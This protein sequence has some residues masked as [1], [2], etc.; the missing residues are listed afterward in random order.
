MQLSSAKIKNSFL[1]LLVIILF[2]GTFSRAYALTVTPIKYELSGDPGQVLQEKLTLRNEQD[3]PKTYYPSYYNFQAEG[4]TGA[5]T[6]TS[7]KEDL[8]TWMAAPAGVELAAGE[9]KE[10]TFTISI[11]KTAP[12]GGYFA[13]VL[14]GTIPPDQKGG[15]LAIGAQTGPIVLLRVNGD[16]KESASVIE[17]KTKGDRHFYTSLPVEMYYRFQNTGADRTKPGGELVI[18]NIFGI[19]SKSQTPNPVEGNV[20]PGQI[21]KFELM[22]KKHDSPAQDIYSKKTFFDAVSYEWRNFALGY[23]TANLN[24]VYGSNNSNIS[25]S[26]VKFAVFP[27]QLLVVLIVGAFLV[28]TILRTLVRRYNKWLIGQAEMALMR[29]E[30]KKEKREKKSPKRMI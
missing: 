6:F 8:A 11:P 16:I 28:Y 23:F 24:L 19:K 4:E 5:P 30:E 9:S 25:H 26:E 20:L 18:R 29:A 12:P 7:A 2:A 27:W 21:R 3:E 1:F 14:Y 17:F 15:T 10:I 22:W 13:A